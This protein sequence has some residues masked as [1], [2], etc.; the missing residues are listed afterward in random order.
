MP[1]VLAHVT[2]KFSLPFSLYGVPEIEE[3]IGR[4][5]EL[6]KMEEALRANGPERR[7]VVIHGL[8]GMGK[9]QLAI[10]F[11]KDHRDQYL[12][13]FWLNGKTED[14]LKQSFVDVAR[15]LHNEHENSSLL[16]TAATSED[17]D[18]AVTSVR[19]WLSIKENYRWMLV[20][21]N[22]DNPKIAG[23]HDPQAYD[24]RRYFPEAH[25]GSIIITTRSSSLRIGKVV[26]VRKLQVIEEGIA[27]LSSASGREDLA[28]G[29]LCRHT[30][31]E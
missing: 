14:M 22:I 12:A 6:S 11:L 13:T 31:I 27:V 17:V 20:F 9:T 4:K 18:V 1:A 7:V 30:I 3:F 8:G 5:A 24:V 25:H 21:D 26:S 29:N 23:N 28:H 15:R 2:D 16:R 19:K 10:K